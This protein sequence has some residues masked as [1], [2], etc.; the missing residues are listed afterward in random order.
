MRP[1]AEMG[2]G[3][4]VEAELGY[5]AAARRAASTPPAPTANHNGH[6]RAEVT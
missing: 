1:L 2:L 4:R 5:G 3:E 6:Q